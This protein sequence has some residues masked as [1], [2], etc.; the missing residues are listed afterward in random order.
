V[1]LRVFRA[2]LHLAPDWWLTFP[3]S[4]HFESS[5]TPYRELYQPIEDRLIHGKGDFNNDNWKTICLPGELI[6]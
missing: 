1:S 6:D 4:A 3:E 5:S 2:P